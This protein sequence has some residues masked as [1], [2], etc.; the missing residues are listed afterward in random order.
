MCEKWVGWHRQPTAPGSRPFK[1][2]PNL[3]RRAAPIAT[4][5]CAT[6]L[7]VLTDG[8][9]A[10]AAPRGRRRQAPLHAPA[11]T[12]DVPPLVASARASSRGVWK[13]A[14]CAHRGR[15]RGRCMGCRRATPSGGDRST[16]PPLAPLPFALSSPPS[17]LCLCHCRCQLS[18]VQMT[19][20]PSRKSPHVERISITEG[21]CTD[22]PVGVFHRIEIYVG[23]TERAEA[24]SRV[25]G[26]DSRS[27]RRHR[28]P[29]RAAPASGRQPPNRLLPTVEQ[30]QSTVSGRHGRSG[31]QGGARVK[32]ESP[33]GATRCGG[34]APPPS[35]R[36]VCAQGPH[37]FGYRCPNRRYG[38]GRHAVVLSTGTWASHATTGRGGASPHPSRA[39]ARR[40]GCRPA[41]RCAHCRNTIA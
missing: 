33:R 39:L 1:G 23:R 11:R 21:P 38:G 27:T 34:G 35:P 37:E 41:N 22:R 18:R 16:P 2:A 30:A 26:P 25:G 7:E 8:P 5:R 17:P 3:P 14:V 20:A 9:S 4:L 10:S 15:R 13:P 29:R 32:A 12:A 36:L 6:P 40:P 31:V 19:G 24:W 28:G